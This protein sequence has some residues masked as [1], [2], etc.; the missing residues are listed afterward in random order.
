M[1]Q[2]SKLQIRAKVLSAIS[3]IKTI[4]DL[5]VDNLNF[6]VDFFSDIDDKKSLFD[7]FIKEYLKLNE[8]EYSFCSCILKEIIPA[9][10]ME[11]KIFEF[12]KS[13]AYSDE[14]KYKLVQLLR[15]IGT[16]N[17][18]EA[19]PQYFNNPQ[20]ILDKETKKLLSMAMY[21]PETMLD[22]LDFI[23]S[24]SN[25]DKKLLLDSLLA[26]YKG[27]ELANII[28]PVLY[29]DFDKDIKLFVIEILISTKSSIGLGAI[30][31]LLKTSDDKDIS[32]SCRLA[33]K[34]LKLAGASDEK[35][36]VCIKEII[37]DSTP[38]NA[39]ST[40]PDGAGNQAIIITRE[41][42]CGSIIFA[43]FVVNDKA[44]IID[45]FGFY[46]ISQ[47]EIN[48]IITKFYKSEGKYQVPIEYAKYQL[49]KAENITTE[50]K[51]TFPY[52]F[53]CWNTYTKDISSIEFDFK[54]ECTGYKATKEEIIDILTEDYTFRWYIKNEDSPK[55]K[56]LFDEIYNS[57]LTDISVINN[58]IKEN[59]NSVFDTAEEKIWINRINQL[60]Y[61]LSINNKKKE[62]EKFA[63]IVNDKNI[64]ELF[65]A[66]II[67]RS[68]VNNL[69]AVKENQKD[70][71]IKTNIFKHKATIDSPYNIKQIDTVL[72]FLKR[73]WIDE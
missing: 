14:L 38:L 61:I 22:F 24:V 16:E 69:V 47:N 55:L 8:K 45:C 23:Y 39:Y 52:E 44:G 63:T 42:D 70:N 17:S 13:S 50:L 32:N 15:I 33:L 57:E 72:D 4:Q 64:L 73:N 37:K 48:R 20:E 46:N 53:I 9:D 35:E 30:N 28:Y 21:N 60:A 31:Y 3:E 59:V 62:A 6:F 67:Q 25:S 66:I 41:H 54:N 7:I 65:K 71:L 26:D 34:K 51:K 43:A 10:Y 2:L 49:S 58:K 5:N 27:D 40:I 36:T 19:I 18:I 12:L 29:S 11:N 1:P 68:I 56:N